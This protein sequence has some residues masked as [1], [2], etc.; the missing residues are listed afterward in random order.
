MDLVTRC[1]LDGSTAK[2]IELDLWIYP[3]VHIGVIPITPAIKK[4][5]SFAC[6]LKVSFF[7]FRI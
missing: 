3:T 1:G 4:S 7:S 6:P 2:D 5:V